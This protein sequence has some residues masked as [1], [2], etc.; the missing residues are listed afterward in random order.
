MKPAR[1][2]WL[3]VQTDDDSPESTT[4]R[5]LAKSRRVTGSL[6]D[7]RL[8][9]PSVM[10]YLKIIWRRC[11]WRAEPSAHS[12]PSP[13]GRASRKRLWPSGERGSFSGRSHAWPSAGPPSCGDV[14]ISFIV[15]G[16]AIST[17]MLLHHHSPIVLRNSLIIV[18][19]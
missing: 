17:F 3:L 8:V 15:S 16:C 9:V 2:S 10:R 12:P 7:C 6:V 18:V 19:P 5:R 1:P 14:I 13:L 11:A 4:G